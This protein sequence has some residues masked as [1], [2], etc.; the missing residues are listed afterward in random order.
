[1]TV[2]PPK[3]IPT[4]ESLR[5]SVLGFLLFTLYATPLSIMIFEHAIPHHLYADGSQLYV[6]FASGDSILD[7]SAPIGLIRLIRLR[8]IRLNTIATLLGMQKPDSHFINLMM[9]LRKK[10]H[11]PEQD[12]LDKNT[13]KRSE[14]NEIVFEKMGTIVL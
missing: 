8:L 3:P 12:L 11:T 2:C 13:I 10:V 1:M 14:T 4:L 7:L 6:S 5:G 9:V